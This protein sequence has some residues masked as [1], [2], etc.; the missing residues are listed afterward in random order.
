MSI[1]VIPCFKVRFAPLL[2]GAAAPAV[3]PHSGTRSAGCVGSASRERDYLL[4]D[5]LSVGAG[6]QLPAPPRLAGDCPILSEPRVS[7]LQGGTDN[8]SPGRVA[9]RTEWDKASL[10][11][12]QTLAQSKS[13][14][15]RCVCVCVCVCRG[16]GVQASEQV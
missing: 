2:I 5:C 16:D 3:H 7:H 13:C 4:K 11:F 15:R 12:A 10:L 9:V 6:V 1:A 8:C 14:R